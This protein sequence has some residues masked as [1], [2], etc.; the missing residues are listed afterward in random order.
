MVPDSNAHGARQ[1]MLT[2]T[3]VTIANS[4]VLGLLSIC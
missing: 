1:V 3:V 4:P 2:A